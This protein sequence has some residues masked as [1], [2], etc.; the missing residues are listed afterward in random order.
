MTPEQIQ[1]RCELVK[2]HCSW[3]GTPSRCSRASVRQH[4]V[5]EAYYTLYPDGHYFDD[6]TMRFF[7][8]RIGPA[9]MVGDVYYFITSERNGTS[10][11]RLF[12]L[13]CMSF[14]EASVANNAMVNTVGEFQQYATRSAALAALRNI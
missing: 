7:D 1:R 9:R 5:A 8:S 13:R 14:D 12:S 10:N 6:D 2:R 3:D 11:P 4:H